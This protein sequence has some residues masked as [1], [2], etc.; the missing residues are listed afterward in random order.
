MHSKYMVAVLNL[1]L[2]DGV[3]ISLNNF[4]F[5]EI[6][7]VKLFWKVKKGKFDDF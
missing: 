7:D 5:F 6:V 3:L 4:L 2:W 1:L